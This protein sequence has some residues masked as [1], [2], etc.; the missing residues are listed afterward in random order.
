MYAERNLL[1]ISTRRLVVNRVSTKTF[2]TGCRFTFLLI[3]YGVDD[4]TIFI[5]V[6]IEGFNLF[7][8]GYSQVSVSFVQGRAE[9]MRNE[10]LAFIPTLHDVKIIAPENSSFIKNKSKIQKSK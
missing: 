10:Y 6:G 3:L 8:E 7:F 5:S 9:K 1:E 2:S 4:A